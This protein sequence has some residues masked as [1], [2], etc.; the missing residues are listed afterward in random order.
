MTI[1]Q[2]SLDYYVYAYMREDGTPYYIGKGKGD[3][4]WRKNKS[5]RN[6]LPTDRNRIIICE[7]NLTDVGACAIERRLIRWYGREDDGTGILHNKT[8]GGDGTLGMMRSDEHKRKQSEAAKARWKRPGEKEKL[9]EK[10]KGN[11]YGKANKGWVP[12]E[13]TKDNMSK[14]AKK[15]SEENPDHV[16][17]LFTDKAIKKM[18]A[19][20]KAKYAAMT[21][22]ERKESTKAMRDANTGSKRSDETK[23]KISKAVSEY[24]SENPRL[25]SEERKQK[26]SESVKK[27][28]AKKFWSSK[29]KGE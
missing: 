6:K 5:E 3:R 25:H 15:R 26:I 7:A 24:L 14:A 16:K 11:D 9:T 8:D 19:T 2:P 17:H 13:E 27:A 22:E 21:P 12:S 18:S 28:R 4:A 10:M 23:Q 1:Y 20:K 29:K